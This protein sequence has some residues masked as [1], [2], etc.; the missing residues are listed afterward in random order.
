MPI[1]KTGNIHITLTFKHF[2]VTFVTVDKKQIPDIMSGSVFLH[3][4]APYCLLICG[5][6]DCTIFFPH[7]L[8]NGTIEKK[9]DIDC[10]CAF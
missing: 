4:S 1:N 2:G 3:F 9:K 10:K 5:L 6:P 8:I 7:Y